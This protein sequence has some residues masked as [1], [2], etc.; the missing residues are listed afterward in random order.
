MFALSTVR[1]YSK[2]R[3]KATTRT[4]GRNAEK[5]NNY[6]QRLIS[7]AKQTD[8][9]LSFEV[10]KIDAKNN[11]AILNTVFSWDNCTGDEYY[12]H[13][14]TLTPNKLHIMGETISRELK[15]TLIYI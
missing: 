12:T 3:Q 5:M 10:V 8:G 7:E 14:I 1:R 6:K 11:T 13:K 4:V 2:N 15:T 9:L